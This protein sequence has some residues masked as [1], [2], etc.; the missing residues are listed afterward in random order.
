[1]VE[2][3]ALSRPGVAGGEDAP[4]HRGEVRGEQ[5]RGA[6][7]LLDLRRVPVV[8]Q[9]VGDEVLVDRAKVERLRGGPPGPGHPARRVHDERGGGPRERSG[10]VQGSRL[11]QRGEGEQGGGRVAPR[12]GDP[13]GAGERGAVELG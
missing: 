7:S 10:Q 8:E 11:H 12:G 2:G 9:A 3:P 6:E 5:H 13:S 4:H 1:M